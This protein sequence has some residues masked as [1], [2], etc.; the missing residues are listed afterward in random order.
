VPAQPAEVV[1][2]AVAD[3]PAPDDDHARVGWESAHS[4]W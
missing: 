2:N 4:G 1:S 3:D